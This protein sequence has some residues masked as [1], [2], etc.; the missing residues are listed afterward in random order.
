MSFIRMQHMLGEKHQSP[1]KL[2]SAM[3]SM[4]TTCLFKGT[5]SFDCIQATKKVRDEASARKVHHEADEKAPPCAAISFHVAYYTAAKMALRTG[6][7]GTC[8][9][10]GDQTKQ[11]Q[12]AVAVTKERLQNQLAKCFKTP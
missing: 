6:E 8:L 9:F 2:T 3:L 7:F 5:Q 11:A 1:T 4:Y 10:P 12:N